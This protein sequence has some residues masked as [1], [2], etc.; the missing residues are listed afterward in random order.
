VKSGWLYSY[1]ILADGQRQILY[2]HKAG[3]MA[4]LVDL[5][6]KRALCSLRSLRPCVLHPIP[7]SALT[8]ASFLTPS[9]ASFFLQSSAEMH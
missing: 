6:S 7:L 5:G 8:S 9:I 2:L 3:D 1:C 4:G